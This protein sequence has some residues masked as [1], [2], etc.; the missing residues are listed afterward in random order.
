M[1]RLVPRVLPA[2]SSGDR[3]PLLPAPSGL[4]LR[5]GRNGLPETCR[6]GLV[7]CSGDSGRYSQSLAEERCV[8]R[9]VELCIERCVEPCIERCVERSVRPSMPP[10]RCQL[11]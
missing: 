10:R 4:A 2:E 9:C 1:A 6:C 11:P 7:S 5:R 8:E 3:S